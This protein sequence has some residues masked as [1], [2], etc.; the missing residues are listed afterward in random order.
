MDKQLELMKTLTDTHGISG[1]EYNVKKV[2]KEYL[3]PVSDEIV[4][5]NLG[6]VY[7]KRKAKTGDK[8]ILIGGHLDEIGFMITDIDDNGFLKFTTVGGWWSQVM[9]SQRMNVITD[10][11]ILTGVIGSKPPHILKPDERNK[12]VDIKDMFID[13]GVSSK[14]EAEEAGVKL[15]DQVTPHSEFTEMANKNYLLAKAWDNRMG[16][17]VAV[18]VLQNLKGEDVNINVVSGA[19]VQEEVGLRGAKTS[20]YTVH[21]DLAIS[22]DVGIAWDT[23]GMS[24]N[25]GKG[26]LGDGPLLVLMDASNI[27]HV[28]FRRHIQKVA[29]E[30]GI[31]VQLQTITGGGTDSGGF[32]GAH[33]GVPSV[34]IGV[35][36]RYMHS[37]VSILHKDDYNNAVKLITEVVK[38]LDNHKVDE[39]IW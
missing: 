4:Q 23:P 8:T 20:A 1:F 38:S 15:G 18:E 21:P 28:G 27:G 11:G 12:A 3:T 10:N 36:L 32:H 2:M 6:S 34:N 30:K 25:D 7:G 19:T 5:D 26:K 33:Q 35:P 9:L 22:V 16:C 13:I 39:I 14:E 17:G 29:D 37:N 31:P 24:A